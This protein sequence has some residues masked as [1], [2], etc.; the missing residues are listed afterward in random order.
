MI[1]HSLGL[2]S[3]QKPYVYELNEYV[4]R[5]INSAFELDGNTLQFKLS[6]KRNAGSVLV[7]DPVL[8][9][10]TYS[11]SFA[12]NFGYT[13]TY[14]TAGHAYAGG[15]VFGFG[16]PTTTGAFMMSL[17]LKLHL[18]KPVFATTAK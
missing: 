15:T 17:C 6:T 12:D 2:I 8:V 11:G 7:I 10:S 5:T 13:A 1:R 14:D 9:F 18:M 3:E 16:F 4:K